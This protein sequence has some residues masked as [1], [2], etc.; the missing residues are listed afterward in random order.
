MSVTVIYEDNH[1]IAVNKRSGDLS[2]PDSTE[3]PSLIE[4]IKEDLKIRYNKPGN[5]FLGS[6]HRLDRPVTGAIIYSKTSKALGRMN[7]IFKNKELNKIYL[8]LVDHKPFKDKGFLTHYLKKD[9]YRNKS[10]VTSKND[11]EAKIS[12]LEYKTVGKFG[13]YW[14][15]RIKLYTGRHHQIR[16]QLNHIGCRIVGDIK[17]GF[18]EPNSDK[19][20]C[21]HCHTI[22][23]IH[24]VS[25]EQIRITAD[26]P[27]IPEWD[28]IRDAS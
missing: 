15:L 21:L 25:K 7:A 8:A 16:V 9:S 22:E 28:I 2:Q 19:S 14:L 17:Y 12:K 13:N 11:S 23:F 6:I 10:F 18:P 24:P 3:D 26:L 4:L 5:V 20:I 27:H 1:L